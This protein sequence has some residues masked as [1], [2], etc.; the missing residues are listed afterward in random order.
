MHPDSASSR[1]EYDVAILGGG[2]TG[3][4]V[5][6]LVRKYNP[7]ARIVIIEKATFPRDHVG[8]SQLPSVSRVLDEMEVWDKVEAA[9]FPVK[10]GASY[11]WGKNNDRWDIDFFPVEKWEEE[12]RPARFEGQR[13]YTAFQ[14]ERAR[15]D[16]I[17]LRHAEDMGA[18]VRE[19]VKVDDIL[20]NDDR[21]ESLRLSTGETLTAG[22]YVDATGAVGL[23]RRELGIGTDAPK[24]L[25]NV[26]FW[27]YWENAEWAIEIGR[28]A[29]R[30]QVRSLPYGWIW[31]IPLGPTKTSVG[32]ICPAEYFRQQ[33]KS[34]EELYHEA[35]RAQP[36]IARLMENATAR[37]MVES[38]K[39]WSHVAD[40]LIGENWLIAGEAAGF[41]DPILAA[42]MSLAHASGR[43]AAYT[44]LELMR[45]EHDPDWLRQRYDER[46]RTNIRQHIRFAQYW[47]SANGQFSD[48]KD[49]CQRIAREAGL[50]LTPREAWRWLSQGGFTSD[51][52]GQ[53][54]AG[55]FDIA[56]AKQIIELFD[57]RDR[58][59]GWLADGYNVFKMNIHGAKAEKIGALV[60]GRIEP[61]EC[62]VR[63]DNR[64]VLHG[65]YR[66][67]VDILNKTSD[68]EEMLKHIQDIIH[69]SGTANPGGLFARFSQALDAMIHEGWVIRK[70]DRKRPA[71][72]A[73]HDGQSYIRYATEGMQAVEKAGKSGLIKSRLDD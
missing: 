23:L 1:P 46:N 49:H 72:R 21:I 19:G 53:A 65:Y 13:R 55:S 58:K 54:T 37:G 22:F 9:G 52:V 61:V 26:A 73:T 43:D 11:T 44:I 51:L 42:G 12:T 59:C 57:N 35:I 24:E 4:T 39:D 27:E 33:K 36:D 30:V 31:F 3:S 56:S 48:L 66:R 10:I 41:A 14:V 17:L 47:Y 64:L 69:K 71:I 68:G 50:K 7:E 5:A 28:G 60:D 6:T 62:Y 34:K 8:E 63:G 15:Y 18:Q 38:C 70:R 40:R 20:T 32:L 29:T 45:G 25:R 67:L 16:D 2:P